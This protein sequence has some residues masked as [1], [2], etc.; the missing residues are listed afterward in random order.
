MKCNRDSS[1]PY[2]AILSLIFSARLEWISELLP[3]M[4]TPGEAGAPGHVEISQLHSDVFSQ[5][6]CLKLY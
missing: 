4:Q 6:I 5:N 1:L 3:P 2:R